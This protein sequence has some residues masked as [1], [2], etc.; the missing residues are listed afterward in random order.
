MK[1]LIGL[2]VIMT[3]VAVGGFWFH[4]QDTTSPQEL[5]QQGVNEVGYLLVHQPA[6]AIAPFQLTTHLNKPFGNEQLLGNWSILFLGYTY[7]PDI[8]PTTLAMFK[9][10]YTRLTEVRPVQVVFVSADPQRDSP[11]RLHQYINYFH[12]EFIG[13]TAPHADLYPFTRNLGLAYAMFDGET[14]DSYLVDHSASIVVVNPEGKIAAT[15]KPMPSPHG[16]VPT[17]QSSQL[18]QDFKAVVQEFSQ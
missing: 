11:E 1:K 7:C 8:C 15:L 16:Y 3:L 9:S 2:M 5:S 18:L 12:P 14:P 17:V 10:V 4:Q 6:R 13:A